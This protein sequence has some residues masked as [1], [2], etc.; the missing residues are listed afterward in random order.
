MVMDEEMTTLTERGT[1]TLVPPPFG[2]DVVGCRWV[3][4][5]KFGPDGTM[6]RYKA[7]LI[8]KGFTQTY[9]VDYFD[10]FSPMARL[11]TIRVL[12]SVAVN[13][14][15]PISQLDVKN[16]FLY[17]DLQ[18]AVYME[19]PPGYVAQGETRVC[20]LK[21]A[22]YGLKQS[23]RAWFDKFSDIVTAVG[24]A[25]SSADHSLF[26]RKTSLG[27]VVLAVYVDGILLTSDD[28][29]GV[30]LTK[31][32]LRQHLVTKDMGSPKYFLGFEISRKTNSLVLSQH[33]YALDL[34]KEAG[35]TG[36]KPA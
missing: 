11:S 6:D 18:E 23:P 14:D 15:W 1:W 20:R 12:L 8:S 30:A 28:Q 22:I 29:E 9:E 33:K 25:R 2:T 31:Q 24:F 26:I 16:A 17:G 32:H 21:K 27:L 19:Q 7:R 36:A 34:L 5:V 13:R 4:V 35:L 10:T 3:F